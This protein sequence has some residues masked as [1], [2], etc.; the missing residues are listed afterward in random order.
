MSYNFEG[1]VALVTGATS[2]IGKEIA[3]Q[4]LIS[5]AKVIINYGHN[6]ENFEKTKQELRKYEEKVQ[7]FKADIS[8]ENEIKKMFET[9]DQLDYLVNNAGTNKDASIEEMNIEDFRKII[10][11]NLVGKVITTKYAIQLLKNS[12]TP[13]IVNIASRLGLMPCEEASAYASA[14]AG[15]INFT[16]ASALELAKYSIR[17]NTVSPGLTI[18]PL[19]LKGWTKKE[20]EEQKATNLLKRLGETTDIANAV[21]FL[22]SEEASYIN[23]ENINVNGGAFMN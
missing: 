1:K 14:E 7:F 3:K 8:Q 5:G 15:I 2:G 20:I 16:K 12:N 19:A 9:I 21:L 22:L 4:L 10:D 13:A 23:G 6:E 18:T 11:V 17:V